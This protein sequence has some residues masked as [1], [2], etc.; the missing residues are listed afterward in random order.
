MNRGTPATRF[1]KVPRKRLVA[2]WLLDVGESIGI[3]ARIDQENTYGPIAGGPSQ[4]LVPTQFGNRISSGDVEHERL[5]VLPQIPILGTVEDVIAQVTMIG[6]AG[7][8][9]PR[10]DMDP[11]ALSDR[12]SCLR[13]SI[14]PVSR[15]SDAQELVGN[16]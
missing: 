7:N 6:T 2:S 14:R 1:W 15:T 8:I 16:L 10:A 12:R 3:P 5:I 9:L 13:E 4:N 11:V